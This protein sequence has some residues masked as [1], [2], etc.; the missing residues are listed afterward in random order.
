MQRCWG[1]GVYGSDVCVNVSVCVCVC[2]C[3]I[4]NLITAS[5]VIGLLFVAPNGCETPKLAGVWE[6]RAHFRARPAPSGRNSV[7]PV[8]SNGKGFRETRRGFQ[9]EFTRSHMAGI[10]IFAHA[11]REK[12][13]PPPLRHFMR[14]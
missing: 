4:Y 9:G 3:V 10:L 5:T 14:H 1:R 2:V 13:T 7:P 6:R 8:I 12:L 11:G